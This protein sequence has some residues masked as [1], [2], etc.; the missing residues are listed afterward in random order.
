MVVEG[1][2]EGNRA[3]PVDGDWTL[4]AVVFSETEGVVAESLL[5]NLLGP[6]PNEKV[7]AAGV[8]TLARGPKPENLGNFE[9]YKQS[10]IRAVI[11]FLHERPTSA[12]PLEGPG[13]G[14]VGVGATERVPRFGSPFILR[15]KMN[16]GKF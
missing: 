13:G 15:I 14:G 5:P 11:P 7:G 12:V 3:D 9:A 10:G 1:L 16:H 6:V 2:K 8:G 4:F